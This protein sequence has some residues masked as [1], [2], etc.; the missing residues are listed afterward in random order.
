MNANREP[1]VAAVEAG[2]TKF[3]CGVGS[4]PHDFS[5]TT[6]P[7]TE[8]PADVLTA[9]VT[10]ESSNLATATIEWVDG[11]VEPVRSARSRAD[12]IVQRTEEL[13]ASVAA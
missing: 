8:R 10:W 2:G 9:A 3:V 1:L 12:A 6:L 4:G 13:R 11:L 5:R 7:T